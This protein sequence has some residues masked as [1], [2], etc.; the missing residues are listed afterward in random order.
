MA[1]ESRDE[2]SC[3]PDV[4]RQYLPLSGADQEAYDAA[5]LALEQRMSPAEREN[6]DAFIR[7]AR[8]SLRPR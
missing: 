2:G 8:K 5:L 4:D 7:E 6:F 1:S 3:P